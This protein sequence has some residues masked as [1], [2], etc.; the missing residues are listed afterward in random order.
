[1]QNIAKK[2]SDQFDATLVEIQ[3]L[4][5]KDIKKIKT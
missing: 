1:M 5:N 3:F 2:Q 4:T